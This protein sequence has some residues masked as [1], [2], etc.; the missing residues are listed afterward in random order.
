[1]AM[2]GLYP[3]NS[4]TSVGMTKKQAK[5]KGYDIK[6]GRIPFSAGKAKLLVTPDFL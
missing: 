4:S 6:V 2:F 5:E 1:M 3:Y